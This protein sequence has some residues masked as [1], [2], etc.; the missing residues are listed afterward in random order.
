MPV[1][2]PFA[3]ISA[4]NFVPFDPAVDDLSELFA[5]I[6]NTLGG[7]R[8]R[9]IAGYVAVMRT[10]RRIPA[11][12]GL[13]KREVECL[14]W[15]AIGK[16]DREIA[17]IIALSH[18][19]IRYHISR[20]SEKLDS[21]NGATIFKAGQLGLSRCERLT[22]SSSKPLAGTCDRSCDTS[23]QSGVHRQRQEEYG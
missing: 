14:R 6:G 19:T 22:G 1:H 12:C 13:F 16:T 8:R 2:L 9:F 5:A 20:A 21:I 11:D 10:K 4:S 7:A 23:L 18:A 3:Q 17:M 15:A